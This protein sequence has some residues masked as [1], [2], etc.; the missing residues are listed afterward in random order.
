MYM[1]PLKHF[2]RKLSVSTTWKASVG[3]PRMIEELS[4]HGKIWVWDVVKL[5]MLVDPIHLHVFSRCSFTWF[6]YH[7]MTKRLVLLLFSGI[8]LYKYW[9]KKTLQL[10]K[11]YKNIL[12]RL[13]KKKLPTAINKQRFPLAYFW[14]MSRTINSHWP[15]QEMRSRQI[16]TAPPQLNRYQR[17]NK[18]FNTA[19]SHTHCPMKCFPWSTCFEA[20]WLK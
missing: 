10:N 19:H 20:L 15:K 8:H 9:W 5:Q 18:Y 3:L 12:S 17:W 7:N 14:H 13:T 11:M 1:T 2:K 6:W 16:M 4:I